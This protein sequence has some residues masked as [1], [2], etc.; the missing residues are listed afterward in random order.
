MKTGEKRRDPAT[1][2]LVGFA[3]GIPITIVLLDATIG[4]AFPFDFLLETALLG[5]WILVGVASAGASI[6]A[7]R[8]GRLRRSVATA[9]LPV[10]LLVASS[11]VVGLTRWLGNAGDD[12]RFVVM[13]S[14]YDRIVS[15]RPAKR[16]PRI[17]EFGWGGMVGIGKS[18][19]YDDSDQVPLPKDRRTAGWFDEARGTSLECDGYGS[20]A[21]GGHYDIVYLPC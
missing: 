18:L 12:V 13:R 20:R 7:A 6:S 19:V 14:H 8:N 10:F 1:L 3:I 21:L 11:N 9:A 17:V 2:W 5:L 16:V 15:E 4:G